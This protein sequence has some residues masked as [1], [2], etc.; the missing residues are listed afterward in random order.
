MSYS[1]NNVNNTNNSNLLRITGMA[2]GLDT[3]NIIKQLM[4]AESAPLTRLNQK[5]TQ[6]EWKQDAYR[7]ITNSLRAFKDTYFDVLKPAT[8]MLS[9]T[10]FNK[11]TITSSSPEVATAIGG[12]GA[13]P[14]THTLTV[15]QLATS[16]S[17]ASSTAVTKD[18]TGTLAAGL[19]FVAGTNDEFK[20][21]LNGVTKTLTLRDGAYASTAELITNGSSDGIQNLVDA[22]FGAGKITVSE[23]AVGSGILKFT[24]ANSKITISSGTNDALG[25]LNIASGASNRISTSSTL[26]NL[27]LK[28]GLVF[29]GGGN[30]SFTINGADFSFSSDTTLSAMMGEINN[31]SA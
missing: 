29:D 22:A 14:G 1:L 8:N 2:T 25:V 26:A 9:G 4:Q 3:D 31:S 30:V 12:S 28:T 5:N 17:T 21:T 20:I 23:T 27:S 13:Q 24:A 10:S 19:A 7:D 11:S 16:A 6:L 18:L 15:T